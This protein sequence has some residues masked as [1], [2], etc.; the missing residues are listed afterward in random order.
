VVSKSKLNNR[1]CGRKTIKLK[2]CNNR[3]HCLLYSQTNV[4]LV[5]PAPVHRHVLATYVFAV[6]ELPVCVVAVF[7]HPVCVVVQLL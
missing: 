6:S 1:K 5:V 7:E 4:S 2:F 3:S